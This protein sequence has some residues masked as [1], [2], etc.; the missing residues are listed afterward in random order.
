MLAAAG[1]EL[2]RPPRL[3]VVLTLAACW[4]AVARADRDGFTVHEVASPFQAGP[5]RIKVLVP[6]RLDTGRKYPTVYVLPVEC[7]GEHRYGEGLGEIKRRDL[8]NRYPAVFVAHEFSHL[9]WYADHPT[10]PLVRQ[11]SHFVR[12]VVPFIERC[13]PVRGDAENRWLL[14]FSKSA[15]G[16][17]SL[18][19]R[20]PDRFGKAAAWDAWHAGEV[21][22]DIA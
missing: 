22:A 10:D 4:T 18:L 11:E 7:G 12:V 5:S 6:D 3:T 21:P 19:L 20:H 17:L 8:H 15:W 2:A 16:A 14:G 9:P 13:Y 1:S